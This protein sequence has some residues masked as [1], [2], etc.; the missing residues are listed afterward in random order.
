LYLQKNSL[1]GTVPLALTKLT[2]LQY[3]DV[4]F[5]YM[6]GTLPSWFSLHTTNNATASTPSTYVLW[7]PLPTGQPSE[8]ILHRC[9]QFT[10]SRSIL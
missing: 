7:T 9:C 1:I 3:F 10:I 2:N 4:N 8:Y 6:S 5:N